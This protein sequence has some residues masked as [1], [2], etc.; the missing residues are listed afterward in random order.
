VQLAALRSEERASQG[1]EELEQRLAEVLGETR[2]EVAQSGSY[3][4]LR[5][6]PLSED[7]ARALCDRLQASDQEC[8]VVGR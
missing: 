8:L 7:D 2:I 1:A 6:E 4:V 5:T 3:Y